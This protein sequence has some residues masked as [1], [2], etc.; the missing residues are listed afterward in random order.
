MSLH[1]GTN[2]SSGDSVKVS[3]TVAN[4]SNIAGKRSLFPWKVPIPSAHPPQLM[5][6]N[7]FTRKKELF[8]PRDGKQVK[9]Y[10][11]GPTVYDSS[12]MG[13][14]RAYLSF[15]ILRRVMQ[16]YFGYNIQFVMNITDIDDKIIK[17]AR[18]NHLWEEYK[19]KREYEKE[20]TKFLKDILASV[21]HFKGKVDDEADPDKKKM[22]VG[23]VSKVSDA[24]KK[25]ESL[26]LKASKTSM[27]VPLD[28]VVVA[29]EELLEQSK[30]VMSEWLDFQYG[31]SVNQFS[32]FDKLAKKYENEFLS[33]MQKLNVLPPDVLVRV[34]E[35]IPEIIA[36]VQKIV[37]NGYGY[38]S[39][40]GSVYFDTIAFENSPNHFYAKLVP[41][42][43]GDNEELMK[44]MRES[45]GELSMSN[46]QEKRNPTDFA[47]WK[48]SKSGEPYWESPWGKG[49]PGW[50]IECSAMSSSVCGPSLDIH[51][52]GFDL[53]FPHHDNEIAQVEAYYDSSHWVNYFL[54][55]GTLRIAGLK[56]S[57]SLKNFVTIQEALKRYTARQ[58]RILFLMHNWADVLDYSASSMERA[59]QFEKITNEFFLLVKDYI[60]RYYRPDSNEGYQKYGIRE[61]Q[62]MDEFFKIKADVNRALCDSI[63]TRTAVEKIRELIGLGNAYI[64]EMERQGTI[65]NCLLLRNI[66]AYITWL[67]KV[68]GA[69][70]YSCEIGFP[71]ETSD[72]VLYGGGP[73]TSTETV[74]MPYLTALAEFREKV[75]NI[76]REHKIAGILEE[77]DRLRDEILPELGVRLE[78][79]ASQTCVKLVDRETILREQK[80]KK[81]VEAAKAAERERKLKER[82]EREAMKRIP[83]TEMFKTGE[84]SL[85][86]SKFDEKG[87]PT[88]LANGEEVSKKQRKKLEKLY[89]ARAKAFETKSPED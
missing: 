76:A 63:D 83:P 39:K 11:C 46:L 21:E 85:K 31:K 38:V 62:L 32:V 10:I 44:N 20:K 9:W 25:V 7:S 51:S 19:E 89:D 14:A 8:F 87:I 23:T 52:G 78:D 74:L 43:F 49:R 50:H 5:L 24:V 65:P 40:D 48:A 15:D 33:D 26:L 60:R 34:S 79:R 16:D 66:A 70:P 57:K 22:L 27:E 37:N 58:L 64:L 18:Q 56:M 41:E 53:K 88:H 17:R 35:Y 1:N 13:H 54:H 86:Y 45:E 82:E 77:C 30:D 73:S 47:L 81:A 4:S 80:Q 42:A 6:Y 75:R 68:F 36:Y 3:E 84:E 61:L 55:C 72:S 69:I 71:V 2:S 12:H 29:Q 59:L 28:E 67:L